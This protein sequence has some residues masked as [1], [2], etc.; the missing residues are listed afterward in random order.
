MVKLM[1][2]TVIHEVYNSVKQAFFTVIEE[3]TF[4][5]SIICLLPTVYLTNWLLLLSITVQNHKCITQ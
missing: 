3:E 4:I 1:D 2:N 5:L